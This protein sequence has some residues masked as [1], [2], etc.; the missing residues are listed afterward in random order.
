MCLYPRL[1]KNRKYT[2][3]KKNGGNIPPIIDPRTTLVPIGCQ[4]CIECRKQKA[5]EWQVRL[6]EDIRHNGYAKFITLTFSNESIAQLSAETDAEGY[7]LDNHIATRAVRLFLERWRK[8]YKKSLRHWLVTEL[9]HTGTENIHLH[10]II[11][12]DKPLQK[13]EQIWQYGHIW[14]GKQENGRLVNYVNAKTVN[15]I[16]KYVNKIDQDHK[17][18]KSII[19]TS[20]GIGNGYTN[21]TDA[22]QNRYNHTKTNETY[23]TPQGYRLALPIYYRNKIYSEQERE[24]LWLQK[25]N[26]QERWICGEKVDISKSEAGYYKL[27]DFYRKRNTELGYGNDTKSWSQ[28][29][30]ERQRRILKQKER[31][32]SA[33]AASGRQI[34]TGLV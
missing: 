19:L 6:H 12:T 20:P 27:L 26:K 22:K 16:V 3:T 11:W 34:P 4:Q 33:Y 10:G 32:Q 25:L 15:Y 1:I 31:I 30:Y 17:H 29:Q 8:H 7:E 14:K 18:Y 28:E 13:V 9:G 2:K 21:R 5:R 24:Q 23:R